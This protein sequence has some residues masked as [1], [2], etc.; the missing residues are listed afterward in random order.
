MLYVLKRESISHCQAVFYLVY[1]IYTHSFYCE[2]LIS[3][4]YPMFDLNFHQ[5]FSLQLHGGLKMSCEWHFEVVLTFPSSPSAHNYFTIKIIITVIFSHSSHLSD[6][7][8]QCRNNATD[9][10]GAL[11]FHN[12]FPGALCKPD[13]VLSVRWAQ[14]L[15]LKLFLRV[16]VESRRWARWQV[17]NEAESAKNNQWVLSLYLCNTSFKNPHSRTAEHLQRN[18]TS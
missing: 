3:A 14:M 15:S 11:C 8:Y 9:L 16:S 13:E 12:S 6:P 17:H 10:A 18:N 1:C 4:H 5:K 7:H 2:W